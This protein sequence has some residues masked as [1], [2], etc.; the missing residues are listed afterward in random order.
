MPQAVWTGTIS[1]GLVSV[2]VKLYPA[3]RKKD[4]RFKEIDR[5]TGQRV[6]HERVRPEP[7]PFE[8]RLDDVVLP[9]PHAAGSEA[10]S[11]GPL[12]QLAKASAPGTPGPPASARDGSDDGQVQGY[13]V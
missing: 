5:L 13:D 6:R 1:F 11:A 9:E 7:L 4:V 3:T 2:P 12:R 10:V 8:L